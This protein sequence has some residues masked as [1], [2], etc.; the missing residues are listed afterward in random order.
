MDLVPLSLV[1]KHTSVSCAELG[2]VESIAEFLCGLG[3][4][5][6]H[7]LLYLCQVIFDQH[8]G[9]IPLL[10]I[11]VVDQGV[12]ERVD[13]AGCFPDSRVHKDSGVDT[14]YIF[15]QQRHAVPPV[16]LYVI[17]QLYAILS[18]IIHCS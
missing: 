10:G 8:I 14:D 13:M 3:H 17:F 11:F 15:V 16:F 7:L 9:T 1:F 4:F 18:V 6:I 2:F 12:I 5:L